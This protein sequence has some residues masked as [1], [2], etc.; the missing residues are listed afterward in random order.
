MI[1][2][3]KSS[4][5][6]NLC[7]LL[8][9]LGRSLRQYKPLQTFRAIW[10]FLGYAANNIR[11]AGFLNFCFPAFRLCCFSAVLLP[12]F[13]LFPASL[14][15]CFFASL[16]FCFSAFMIQLRHHTNAPLLLHLCAYLGKWQNY[17]LSTYSE[18]VCFFLEPE[19]NHK[20]TLDIPR[21]IILNHP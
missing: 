9:L 2:Y 8:I 1:Q 13:L 6:A 21:Y 7:R 12:A 17:P 11:R 19:I 10:I 3:L 18:P 4:S 15:F 5:V 16:L 20:Q 14:L